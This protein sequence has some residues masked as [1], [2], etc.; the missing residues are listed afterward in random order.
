MEEAA[1]FMAS[2]KVF[3]H[4]QDPMQTFAV[5]D[6]ARGGTYHPMPCIR[7]FTS[8]VHLWSGR[9]VGNGE[10]G[11]EAGK[12]GVATRKF[13]AALV[14]KLP[15][16]AYEGFLLGKISALPSYGPGGIVTE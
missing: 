15:R 3:S 9:K 4:D 8:G 14:N 16:R 11:P 12:R 5:L 13:V 10:I 6:R 1:S 2:A 7:K